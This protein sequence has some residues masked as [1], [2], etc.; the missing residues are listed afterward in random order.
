MPPLELPR[1]APIIDV[2]VHL[3]RWPFRRLPDDEPERL[4]K[5]LRDQGVASALASSFDGLLHLDLGE[6][7]RR[8]VDACASKGQGVLTPVGAVNLA[9]PNWES[10]VR[11]CARTPEVVGVRLWP[12]YHDVGLDDPRFDDLC[13]ACAEESLLLQLVM[14]LE[15]ARTEHPR[16]RSRK[17]ELAALPDLLRRH[18]RLRVILLNPGKDVSAEAAGKLAQAGNLYFDIGMIEGTGAIGLRRYLTPALAERLLF[19]SHSPFFYFAATTLRLHECQP[20][21]R[22]LKGIL[23]ANARRL[24]DRPR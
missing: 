14:R 5:R 21:E 23:H 8:L 6:V 10:E 9:L 22:D 17:V 2:N 19:G 16:F 15:D 3:S 18:P 7:N 11:W 12:G 24:L 20:K 4:A 13:A 1:Y